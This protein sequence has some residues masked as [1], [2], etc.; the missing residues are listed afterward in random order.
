MVVI[1]AI[2]YVCYGHHAD[3][4]KCE[5][6]T[7]AQPRNASQRASYRP[8]Y[9]MVNMSVDKE[10]PRVTVEYLKFSQWLDNQLVMIGDKIREKKKDKILVLDFRTVSGKATFFALLF[11][12]QVLRGLADQPGIQVMTATFPEGNPFFELEA[13]AAMGRSR[14]ADVVC[15]GCVYPPGILLAQVDLKVIDVQTK[16]TIIEVRKVFLKEELG[17]PSVDA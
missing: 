10:I 4:P 8:I 5:V 14:G 9:G 12:H 6:N 17:G 16:K 7:C 15:I 1:S 3:S 11:N 13:V 2:G